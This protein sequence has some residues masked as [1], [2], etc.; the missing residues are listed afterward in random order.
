MTEELH[1]NASQSSEENES[2]K[3]VEQIREKIEQILSEEKVE[4][5]TIIFTMPTD[6]TPHVFRRGHFYDTT[7][8]LNQVLSAYKTKAAVDLGL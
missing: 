4:L 7:M 1:E 6:N 8:L 3:R 5:A 2:K